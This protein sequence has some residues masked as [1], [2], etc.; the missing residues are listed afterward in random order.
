MISDIIGILILKNIRFCAFSLPNQDF[1]LFI[2]LPNSTSNTPVYFEFAPFNSSSNEVI[3]L[4]AD[5]VIAE[6]DSAELQNEIWQQVLTL[7]TL[8]RFPDST[9]AYNEH[10]ENYISNLSK[11]IDKM[12][13]VGI[14]KFI[15]SRIERHSRTNFEVWKTLKE[16]N[17]TYPSTL[18][19]YF[20][21]EKTGRWMGATPETLGTWQGHKFETMALAAT[22]Q[23]QVPV[24]KWGI[25]EL[26]EHKYVTSYIQHIFER[27]HIE[28]LYQPIKTIW[29]IQLIFC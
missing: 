11:A 24:E 7:P 22:M 1:Q 3:R 17:A 10:K 2:E 8:P 29:K 26:E 27:N 5:L 25:K 16:L 23:K 20:H 4:S 13:V 21:H 9:E 15:Y 28:C 18:T 14:D 19:Y 12:P 6:Y